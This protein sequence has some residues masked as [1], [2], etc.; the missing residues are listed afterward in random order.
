MSAVGQNLFKLCCDHYSNTVEFESHDELP[1]NL[2][3]VQLGC[4]VLREL[5]NQADCGLLKSIV[6]QYYDAFKILKSD[7]SAKSSYTSYKK[8][9]E[10]QAA[11]KVNEI[12]KTEF[13]HLELGYFPKDRL[14]N[15]KKDI[16]EQI[17]FHYLSFKENLE[18]LKKKGHITWIKK[19]ID[20]CDSLEG[21][22]KSL[23]KTIPRLS[24]EFD[25]VR[26]TDEKERRLIHKTRE[27][28]NLTEEES[29]NSSKN[30]TYFAQLVVAVWKK[31]HESIVSQVEFWNKFETDYRTLRK[32]LLLLQCRYFAEGDQ[33][34]LYLPQAITLLDETFPMTLPR[35]TRAVAEF[36][37][38]LHE[39][40]NGEVGK[41]L[42]SI[43]EQFYLTFYDLKQ[44]VTNKIHRDPLAEERDKKRKEAYEAAKVDLEGEFKL[45]MNPSADARKGAFKPC[46]EAAIHDGFTTLAGLNK[47]DV[48]FKHLRLCREKI[49]QVKGRLKL[50]SLGSTEFPEEIGKIE[51]FKHVPQYQKYAS[52]YGELRV[53]LLIYQAN[54]D[55]A[56]REKVTNVLLK[57]DPLFS[58]ASPPVLAVRPH[59]D[60][61]ASK[62]HQKGPLDIYFL[63]SFHKKTIHGYPHLRELKL[64]DLAAYLSVRTS[65]D[66]LRFPIR[67]ATDYAAKTKDVA[68]ASKK[69]EEKIKGFSEKIEE[70][71]LADATYRKIKSE[72]EEKDHETIFNG[73]VSFVKAVGSVIP[74]LTGLKTSPASGH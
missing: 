71:K 53:G 5:K 39:I 55:D 47:L 50:D 7:A 4:K 16:F 64:I 26:K 69:L 43:H 28:M 65:T 45:L 22:L 14:R 59:L 41:N 10:Q 70:L 34:D 27:K 74:T 37:K 19:F 18:K 2:Q 12:F 25:R 54:S 3:I 46:F 38:Q 57:L 44:K 51:E 21:R 49:Q 11:D 73:L 62:C 58:V 13:N 36:C 31:A 23:G 35:P 30:A 8:S 72:L 1:I 56:I 63:L 29:P 6:R 15:F 48:E 60:R 52:A 24:F 68:D 9:S 61:I 67:F 17:I 20:S 33:K 40:A 66:S 42:E 32:A